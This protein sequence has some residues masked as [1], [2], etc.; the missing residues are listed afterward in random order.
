MSDQSDGQASLSMLAQLPRGLTGLQQLRALIDIGR[1]PS[2]HESLDIVLTSADEGSVVVQGNPSA[3]HLNPAGVVHGGYVATVLDTA[4]GC[5]V[6]SVL[7][8]DTGFTTLELKISYHRAV[9][10][11]TGRL[12]AVGVVLSSGRRVAFSEAKLFDAQDRLLASATSSLLIMP[13][14]PGG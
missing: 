10:P 3:K 2:I 6:H 1:Q 14:T 12:R 13:L 11:R 7:P 9:T 4:C 5:A 8:P